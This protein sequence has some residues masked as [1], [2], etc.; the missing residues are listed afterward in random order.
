MPRRTQMQH[1][2][3]FSSW[4]GSEGAA[5]ITITGTRR[6]Y[7]TMKPSKS[8]NLATRRTIWPN[9][10]QYSRLSLR[11]RALAHRRISPRVPFQAIIHLRRQLNTRNQ[12]WHSYSNRERQAFVWRYQ[13]ISR[14]YSRAR[15]NH[16][17]SRSQSNRWSTCRRSSC[18][19]ASSVSALSHLALITAVSAVAVCCGWIIIADGWT[20]A[21]ASATWRYSSTLYSTSA[22][23]ASTL[24]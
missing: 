23:N 6:L 14:T 16:L 2:S 15:V 19:T 5:L 20:I 3:S 24:S 22:F 21:W 17:V 7:S 18:A 12:E 1:Q 10:R 13:W 8:M 11:F 9:R 4:R